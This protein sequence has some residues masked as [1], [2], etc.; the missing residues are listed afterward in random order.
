[1]ACTAGGSHCAE[2]AG[3]PPTCVDAVHA[4]HGRRRG[5]VDTQNLG[6]GAGRHDQGGVQRASWQF[7]VIDVLRCTAYLQAVRGAVQGRVGRQAGIQ[8]AVGGCRMCPPHRRQNRWKSWEKLLPSCQGRPPLPARLRP[9]GGRAA[10]QCR[11]RAQGS[12]TE[13]RGMRGGHRAGQLQTGQGGGR[14]RFGKQ[15]AMHAGMPMQPAEVAAAG[16]HDCR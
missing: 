4:G 10:P 12:S 1:M 7:D 13:G 16:V 2:D 15:R 8:G 11:P 6:V 9:G 14:G 5:A 3:C